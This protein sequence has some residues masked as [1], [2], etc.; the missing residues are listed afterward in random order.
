MADASAPVCSVCNG[1]AITLL[2]L[3][4]A[5]GRVLGVAPEILHAAPRPGNIAVWL[6]DAAHMAALHSGRAEVALAGVLAATH[7]VPLRQPLAR[8]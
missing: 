6:D 5:P 2:D 7:G 3:A 1:T 4:A 8:E